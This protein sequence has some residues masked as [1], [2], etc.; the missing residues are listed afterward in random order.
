MQGKRYK[1][2]EQKIDL[3]QHRQ[4]FVTLMRDIRVQCSSLV[5]GEQLYR[6]D[7]TRDLRHHKHWRQ[8]D[9]VT[10]YRK[11]HADGPMSQPTVSRLENTIKPIERQL[12]HRLAG[13]LKMK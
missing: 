3:A 13:N 1:T 10:E 5:R 4:K 6:A 8:K 2:A 9:L 11:V 7:V 12:A